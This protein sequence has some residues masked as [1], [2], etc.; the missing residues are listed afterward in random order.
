M[1][2]ESLVRPDIVSPAA[3]AD[4]GDLARAELVELARRLGLDSS[5]SSKPPSS[6]GPGSDGNSGAVES[7]TQKTRKRGG[8]PGHKKHERPLIPTEDC[9]EL[10]VVRPDCCGHCGESLADVPADTN[11]RRHQIV[12][13]P[14]IKPI[15]IEYQLQR[16]RC[17]CCGLTTRGKLP[18]GVPPG[19]FGPRVI[20]LATILG[21]MCRLSHRLTVTIFTNVFHLPL[22]TGVISKLRARGRKCLD[23]AWREIV[24]NVCSS[25]HLHADETSWSQAGEKAW[26]WTATC[27]K[28]TLF[29]IRDSRSGD[30]ARELIGDSSRV[31]VTDRY[32]GYAWLDESRHQYCWS[33]L[34]RDF[35]GMI[36]VGGA[37]GEIGS[38]LKQAG[39]L[40]IHHWK[41]WKNERIKWST[42]LKLASGYRR[43]IESALM[44]GL[45]CGINKFESMCHQLMRHHLCLWTF[46]REQGLQPTNN[47]GERALRTGVIWRKLS[48]GT[49]SSEGSRYVETILSVLETCRQNNI[50]PFQFVYDSVTATL[51][52]DKTPPTLFAR[53]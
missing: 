45:T 8:Q 4:A 35:Q 38:R 6:D 10:H 36:S 5:N 30:V 15:V 11:P 16:L 7:R 37:A 31:V 24:E 9:D 51:D 21:G 40:V 13:L 22:S 19:R 2:K 25:D 50:N 14:P 49:N 47:P 20:S 41:R 17:P 12:D 32:S 39:Q 48:F 23:N 28:A 46:L 3:W 34:L 52:P 18:S 1:R 33:H 43:D 27:E 29:F 42:F 44:D 26:L 53:P